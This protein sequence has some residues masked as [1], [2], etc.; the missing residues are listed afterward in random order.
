MRPVVLHLMSFGM[1]PPSPSS[2]TVPRGTPSSPVSFQVTAAGSFNQAVSIS[3]N[4]QI[5]A[6]TCNLTPGATVYPTASSPVN[7]T[8]SIVVPAG[9]TPGSYPVT[10][11][12]TTSGA[13]STLTTSFTLLVTSNPDFVVSEPGSFPEVTVG[14]TGTTG[15]ISVV[16]QD[17]FAG[18]VTLSC[19]ATY[20]AGS[21]SISP[22]SVSSFPA[23][24]TLTING[25]SFTAGAYSI[26]VT[27]TSGSVVH[28]VPVAF[29]VGDYSIS[30]TQ[31][32]T[33]FPGGQA[34]AN[35]KLASSYSYSGSINAT[36]D[37][38]ALPGTM[39]TLGTDW[40]RG[41]GLWRVRPHGF[42]CLFDSQFSPSNSYGTLT[43][44]P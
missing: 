8:A 5:V 17:G 16:S 28:S 3:C 26:S 30:G 32:L 42:R 2:V 41:S 1:T 36:C 11:Q 31:T 10:I 15:S 14:R 34:T 39:C 33:G 27:G 20:G 38:G 19:P 21:C 23:T 25:T 9:T 18:T 35:L 22:T 7:M 12:A 37:A 4:S 29:D 40:R 43:Q 13:P 6:A 24:V 44:S